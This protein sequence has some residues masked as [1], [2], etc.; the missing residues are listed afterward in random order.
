MP[1]IGEM[2][3]NNAKE[4]KSRPLDKQANTPIVVLNNLL[5]SCSFSFI[6]YFD[7]SFFLCSVFSC[8]I[9]NKQDREKNEEKHNKSNQ[10]LNPSQFF[11]IASSSSSFRLFFIELSPRDGVGWCPKVLPAVK[12]NVE[13]GRVK[14]KS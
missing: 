1:F 3:R 12:K 2:Q 13:K 4:D 14:E 9:R 7:S 10:Y 8:E 5:P 11:T 6:R